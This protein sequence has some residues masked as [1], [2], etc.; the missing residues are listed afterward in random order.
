MGESGVPMEALNGAHGA[1]SNGGTTTANGSVTEVK[2][3]VR[4]STLWESHSVFDAW[5][6]AAAGQVLV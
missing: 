4:L 3:R 2:S 6:V 5:L 1:S